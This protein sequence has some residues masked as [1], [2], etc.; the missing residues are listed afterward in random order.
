MTG[1]PY[2]DAAGRF[3]SASQMFTE[4][5]T[6]QKLAIQNEA[7]V[8]DYFDLRKKYELASARP[9]SQQE[10]NKTL[11]TISDTDISYMKAKVDEYRNQNS[12]L[13]TAQQRIALAMQKLAA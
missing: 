4:V 3:C 2:H 13:L 6:L 9:V 11:S 8:G 1:N 10:L 12:Q 5:A 7:Y